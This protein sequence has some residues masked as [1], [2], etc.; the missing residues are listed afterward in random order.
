MVF[1]HR[2]GEAVIVVVVVDIVAMPVVV[3]VLVVAVVLAVVVEVV[4][5]LPVVRLLV[6]IDRHFEMSDA[7]RAATERDAVEEAAGFTGTIGGHPGRSLR[8]GFGVHRL[9]HASGNICFDVGA[10]SLVGVLHP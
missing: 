6:R 7:V 8:G 4:V 2:V 10:V 5:I 9:G 3:V 1:V